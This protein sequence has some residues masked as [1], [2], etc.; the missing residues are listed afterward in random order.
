MY[1]IK[2]H[3]DVI[4]VST[5][6]N[7]NDV[8]EL[9]LFTILSAHLGNQEVTRPRMVE[10][11][12]GH[13]ELPNLSVTSQ[14]QCGTFEIFPACAKLQSTVWDTPAPTLGVHER[15]SAS[16]ESRNK[17]QQIIMFQQG[18][19]KPTLLTSC[20]SFWILSFS[21]FNVFFSCR[22]TERVQMLLHTQHTLY[23]VTLLWLEHTAGLWE[24]IHYALH[25]SLCTHNNNEYQHCVP[26]C[27]YGDA[28]SAPSEAKP[29]EITN[30]TSAIDSQIAL[31]IM[32]SQNNRM[33]L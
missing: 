22:Y 23:S 21:S 33:Q 20:S 2:Y 26:E 13:T 25:T 9:S 11:P 29:S 3:C 18:T 31:Q 1:E 4:H 24:F 12:G 27:M 7:G 14:W 6:C 32:L 10:H 16:P 8:T 5:R 30:L 15:A 19:G 28:A 17:G